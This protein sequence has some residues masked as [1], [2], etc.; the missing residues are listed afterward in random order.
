MLAKENKARHRE[1]A[2]LVTRSTGAILTCTPNVRNV[3]RDTHTQT[4]KHTEIFLQSQ[5]NI[6]RCI[7]IQLSHA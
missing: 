4:H 3:I 1:E 6:Y 7:H 2:G 5:T